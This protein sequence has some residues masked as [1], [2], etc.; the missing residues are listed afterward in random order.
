MSSSMS[1]R[2]KHRRHMSSWNNSRS[3]SRIDNKSNSKSN[4]KSNYPMV[5]S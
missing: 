1:R 4:S 3:S 2:N 5:S